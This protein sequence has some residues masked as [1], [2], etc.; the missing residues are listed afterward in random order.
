MLLI[1]SDVHGRFEV[2]NDQIADAEA[3]CGAALAGVIVLGDFGL[4]E[5]H[6][7]RFFRQRRQRFARPL[8]FVDGNH[9]D[10]DH[11][12]ALVAAYADVFTHWARGSVQA[13][14][15]HRF[16]CLGGAAYMD[17]FTTPE[18]AVVKPR[19]IERCLAHPADAATAVLSHD[20]PAGI[21]VENTPGF[22]HYGTPGFAGGQRL[23]EHFHPGLWLFGHHHRW[24]DTVLGETHYVGLPQSWDG[25]VLLDRDCTLRL[26]R[27]SLPVTPGP[28]RGMLSRLFGRR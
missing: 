1:L 27:H 21:G 22:E 9:E 20:C 28:H 11:F 13:L 10:F 15:G 6:L 5:P 19:D 3:Q 17:A 16:V 24:F 8:A 23:V 2:V 18:R 14:D 12:E 4:V 7:R 25:Y 26:V